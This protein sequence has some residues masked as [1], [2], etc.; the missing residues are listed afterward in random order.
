MATFK[1]IQFRGTQTTGTDTRW[2]CCC[3]AERPE[4]SSGEQC[5]R[6]AAATAAA[7][8]FHTAIAERAVRC[9][10]CGRAADKH[11][12][13]IICFIASAIGGYILFF[14]AQNRQ[15]ECECA[16]ELG[17]RYGLGGGG[18][19]IEECNNIAIDYIISMRARAC[20]LIFGERFYNETAKRRGSTSGAVR[21]ACRRHRRKCTT[22][23]R[24]LVCAMQK[25]E[26]LAFFCLRIDNARE[27]Q[28][29]HTTAYCIISSKNARAIGREREVIVF[30]YCGA[31][32][33]NI[34]IFETFSNF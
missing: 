16:Y 24:T 6:V 23:H 9:L 8:A 26:M 34:R 33:V 15:I 22:P 19:N 4:G 17:A 21:W 10:I 27:K 7:V 11:D 13:I 28:M 18:G 32:R 30:V 12:P 31:P 2:V 25:C 29:H 20:S 5:G 3:S 1:T 14:H